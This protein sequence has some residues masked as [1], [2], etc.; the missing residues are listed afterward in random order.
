ML[1]KDNFLSRD[2]AALLFLRSRTLCNFGGGYHE[3]QF[4]KIILNLNQWFKRFCLKDFL[5]NALAT[6]NFGGS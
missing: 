4:C 3:E 6:L 5:S 2:L 1:F